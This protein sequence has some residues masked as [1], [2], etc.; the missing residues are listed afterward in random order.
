MRLY[1]V[2]ASH[3][4]AAV[5]SALRVKGFEY[6]VTELPPG[7]HAAHQRIRFGKRTVPALKADGQKISGSTAIMRWLEEQRPEPALW[8][9]EAAARDRVH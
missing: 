4:C 6:K 8:P 7:V 2:P 1:V 9:A 3:P 5:E